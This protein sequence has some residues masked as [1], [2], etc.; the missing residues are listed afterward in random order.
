V[1]ITLPV[2]P[3][4]GSTI[5]FEMIAESDLE[6][7]RLASLEFD[8][9]MVGVLSL[10]QGGYWDMEWRFHWQEQTRSWRT[11]GVTFDLALRDGLQRAALVLSGRD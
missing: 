9:L 8:A 5:T 7:L 10:G 11:E 1:P 4:A 2:I 3:E 6:R